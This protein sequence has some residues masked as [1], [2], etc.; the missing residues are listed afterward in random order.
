MKKKGEILDKIEAIKTLD[1]D[2]KIYGAKNHKY[3]FNPVFDQHKLFE[4][5][6]EHQI[7]LPEDYRDFITKIGNGGVGPGYDGILPIQNTIIDL[8]LDNKPKIVLNIPF[9]HNIA[10]NEEWIKNF[11]WDSGRPDLKIVNSY[12]N[13]EHIFGSLQFS[14]IGH[15]CTL[16]LVV[17]GNQKGNVWTDYRADYGGIKP[18]QIKNNNISFI[19]LYIDCLD[20]ILLDLK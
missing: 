11:D 14:H 6:K 7:T 15:G 18:K 13:V 10:W 8:K 2:L 3:E 9:K 17:N 19:D 4:F 20:S 12:M 1:K 16:L 5:E